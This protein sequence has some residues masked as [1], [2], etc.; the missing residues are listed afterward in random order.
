MSV[1][2]LMAAQNY[3]RPVDTTNAMIAGGVVGEGVESL[4]FNGSSFT[5]SGAQIY[6][7]TTHPSRN[8]G[9]FEATGAAW[10]SAGKTGAQILF[11]CL[12]MIKALRG[13][14]KYGPYRF[15][16]CSDYASVLDGDHKAES[17]RTI[18]ERILAIEGVVGV[19]V[20]DALADNV[21][22]CVQVTRDTVDIVDGFQPTTVPWEER[23]GLIENMIVLAA[24]A[25]RV[26][27]DGDGRSGIAHWTV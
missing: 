9:N 16:V 1:R 10:D 3:G 22:V 19:D 24:Q 26:K 7:Y 6:G 18:R 23:G 21:V 14:R 2:E 15:Y 4:L 12:A 17:D 13:D 8:T 5:Y 11:D 27:A 25:P 20:S